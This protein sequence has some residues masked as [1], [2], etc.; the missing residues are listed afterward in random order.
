[1]KVLHVLHHSIPHIDGY[2]IRSKQIVDFQRSIG[3]DVRVLT[4]A[5]HEIE[6]GRSAGANVKAEVIE[7]VVHYRTPLPKGALPR[8]SRR[9]PFARES[10]VMVTLGQSLRRLLRSDSF[11]LVHAHS[12]VLCGLPA[13]LVAS[14]LG[15]P[16]VYEARGFW[17]DGFTDRWPGGERALRYRLSR[18]L[19][20]FVFRRASAVVAIS[21]RMVDEITGRGIPRQKLLAVP[22][23]VDGQRFGPA[24]KDIEIV[25]RHA[26]GGRPVLGFIGSFFHWEGLACLLDAM[27]HVR[28][29]LPEARLVLVG[30]GEEEALVPQWVGQRGLQDQVIVTGHVPHPDV[31]RYY[32][33]MDV[34]VYPRV[35]SRLTDLTPPLKPLEAMA[36]GKAVVGSDVG[37]LRE[38]LGDGKAGLLFKAG[39]SHELA[40]RLVTLLTD[41]SMR[42]QLASAG[43]EYVL[44]EHTWERLV[45]RY[46]NLYLRLTEGGGNSLADTR[47][48]GPEHICR[49]KEELQHDLLGDRSGP[50]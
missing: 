27:V 16:M 20:T 39:D 37:A 6:V 35:K 2:S 44:R 13:V 9:V 8:L 15:I 22:N 23:G 38:L 19:E 46:Q 1:M 40:Q 10:T 4:S 29:R 21:Q 48:T 3:I 31:M 30:G 36:M 47:R 33:V 24:A 49:S 18:R 32:S 28:A 5:Q 45:L 12:P 14:A 41:S 50:E 26:L 25:E 34:L 43:R 11:D 42:E 17:E 7:S